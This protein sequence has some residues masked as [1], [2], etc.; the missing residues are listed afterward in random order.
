MLTGV[1]RIRIGPA[2]LLV[3]AERA[4]RVQYGIFDQRQHHVSRCIGEKSPDL[5]RPVCECHIWSDICTTKQYVCMNPERGRVAP[6]PP[7]F[8]RP[9][10]G[11]HKSSDTCTTKQYVC[12]N[13]EG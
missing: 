5:K 10:Y 9:V 13:P 3:V 11:C 8:K 2:H 4:V 1:L 6:Q 7:E 12:M